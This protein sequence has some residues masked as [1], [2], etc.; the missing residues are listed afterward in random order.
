[1]F[2][3]VVYDVVTCGFA[4][5]ALQAHPGYQAVSVLP[6][7]EAPGFL[8]A[9]HE[10]ISRVDPD[11]KVLLVHAAGTAS[12]QRVAMLRALTRRTTVAP[13]AVDL[14]LAGLAACG[15]WLAALAEAG[16]S[17]GEV[18]SLAPQVSRH[19]PTYAVTS[20]V[21]G[22]DLPVRL[23][24]HVLSWLPGTRFT[25]ALDGSPRVTN[26]A[27]GSSGPDRRTDADAQADP[28][29]VHAAGIVDLVVAGEERYADTL[30]GV[31]GRY[32]VG[33]RRVAE[34][35]ADASTG[36]AALTWWGRARA[37]E[38]CVVPRDLSGALDGAR[39]P[40][41]RCQT[42]GEAAPAACPFC[43]SQEGVLA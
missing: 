7:P 19:L 5:A 25:V 13:L 18:L 41:G 43:L 42:C 3:G 28:A 17:A 34:R 16:L 29:R 36:R 10:L 37:F 14:P 30:A 31:L 23:H 15:T 27:L 21:A 6:E 32:R 38:A 9:G 39:V 33:E 2:G 11:R 40:S 4:P 1:M 20:S 22:L 12:A 8:E 24:Q 35:A 26:G